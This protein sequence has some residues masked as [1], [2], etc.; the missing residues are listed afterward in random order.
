M[1]SELE[2]SVVQF[3]SKIYNVNTPYGLYCKGSKGV[4]EKIIQRKHKVRKKQTTHRHLSELH[5]F[6]G[7]IHMNKHHTLCVNTKTLFQ[8]MCSWSLVPGHFPLVKPWTW[9]STMEDIK[10]I[11]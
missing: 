9:A 6:C 2:G 11:R 5:F 3:I 8:G 4:E 10:R 7:F 1:S